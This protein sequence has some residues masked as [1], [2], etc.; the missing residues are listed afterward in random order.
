MFRTAWATARES[1]TGGKA[2]Y[3]GNPVAVTVV[4]VISL[5]ELMI[6]QPARGKTM[7]SLVGRGFRRCFLFGLL[8]VLLRL[9]LGGVFR[10]FLQ[11]ASPWPDSFCS[12]FFYFCGFA[13]PPFSLCGYAPPSAVV[14]TFRNRSS[15]TSRRRSPNGL[16]PMLSLRLSDPDRER[17]EQ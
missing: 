11:R 8:G 13:D 9:L 1:K 4:I 2:A 17:H 10:L 5:A 6:R 3:L 14:D 12:F 15:T 7:L 16:A